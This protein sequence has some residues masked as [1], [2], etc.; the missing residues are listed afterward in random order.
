LSHDRPRLLGIASEDVS[1]YLT[2]PTRVSGLFA[3]LDKRY[4]LVHFI[5]PRLSRPEHYFDA[6]AHIRPDWHDLRWSRW[7]AGAG[8]NPRRF[9]RRSA[10]A[11]RE[12]ALWDG[13]YD[14]IVQWQTVFAPGLRF[15]DRPYVVYTDNIYPLTQ[16]YYP[17]W[18]PLRKREAATWTTLE[19]LTFEHARHVFTMS[20]FARDAII[21]DYRVPDDRVTRV[22]AGSNSVTDSLLGKRWDTHVAI[23]VGAAN[24]EQKGGGTLLRAWS[25]VRAE[26]PDA[27]LLIV[28]PTPSKREPPPGVRWLGYIAERTILGKLYER[29]AVFVLPSLFETWGHVFL[30]AMGHGLPCIG[31]NHCA[32][33][34]IIE[35]GSTG[36]LVPPGDAP[37]LSEALVR[38]LSDHDLAEAMGRRGH[39][40]A[41]ERGTWDGVADRMRPVLDGIVA[42]A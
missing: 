24:F 20:D 36:L 13:R 23:F 11:E 42:G 1:R 5:Q 32:M 26:I 30:E 12:L 25:Q 9:R 16:R 22:G 6:L 3:A 29:A 33:P 28:G 41:S 31:T 17:A 21:A 37:A 8:L 27:E 39:T 35:D 15:R 18:A 7:K 4:D 19:R 10:I 2:H 14:L 38:L 40:R 34:E